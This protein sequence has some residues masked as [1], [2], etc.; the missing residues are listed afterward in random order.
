[1]TLPISRNTTYA[2]GAQ[3]QSADLNAIQD[4]IVKVY[5]RTRN[6]D[7]LNFDVVNPKLFNNG[8]SNGVSPGRLI[9]LGFRSNTTTSDNALVGITEGQLLHSRKGRFWGV[10]ATAIP[11]FVPSFSAKATAWLPSIASWLTLGGAGSPQHILQQSVSDSGGAW[12]AR[13]DPAAAANRTCIATGVN[14]PVSLA[15]VSRS[16]GGFITSPDGITWTE[17]VHP[18]VSKDMRS[19]CWGGSVFV[20]VGATVVVT[21]PDGITWTDRTANIP[22]PLA[23]AV[24]RDVA[25][26]TKLGLFVAIAQGSGTMTSP[27]GITWTQRTS[28]PNL[29]SGLPITVTTDNAG[30]IYAMGHQLSLVLTAA[31]GDYPTLFRSLD[32][33]VTWED[34][35]LDWVQLCLGALYL[36]GRLIV[37]GEPWFQPNPAESTFV[38]GFGNQK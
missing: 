23:A 4:E 19:V 16:A 6:L 1:M 10:D 35:A 38:I 9:S 21:S 18:A 20:G 33:G 36:G 14:H 31:S 3:V 5:P 28:I 2:P 22:V 15:V 27:D 7:F 29:A 26:D 25:Y 24:W 12:T 30:A 34:T 11:P 32:G 37:F 17:R 8:I 13:T